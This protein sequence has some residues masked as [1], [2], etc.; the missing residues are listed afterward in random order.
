MKRN[1]DPLLLKAS[2]LI[3]LNCGLQILE[4]CFLSKIPVNKVTS[5]I[6]FISVIAMI[7]VALCVR[8]GYTWLKDIIYLSILTTLVFTI[9]KGNE[10]YLSIIIGLLEI[11]TLISAILLINKKE[12]IN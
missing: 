5:W 7:I 6:F 2:N 8:F 12:N 3:F 10:N 1:I 9:K 4:V 11:I